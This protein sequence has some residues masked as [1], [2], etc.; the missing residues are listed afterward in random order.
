MYYNLGQPAHTPAPPRGISL[1]PPPPPVMPATNPLQLPASPLTRVPDSR[2]DPFSFIC[3]LVAKSHNKPGE[4][5]GTGIL[6]T[7]FH[8]LTCAHNIFPPQAPNT[9]EII[10]YPGQNGPDPRCHVRANAWA[11]HPSWRGTSCNT[12]GEDIGIIRLT[13]P[14]SP[15]FLPLKPFDVSALVGAS[16]S[17]AGYP[18]NREPKARH[19]Y[20]SRGAIT[21]GIRIDRCTGDAATGTA[22]GQRLPNITEATNLIAHNLETAASQSGSPM[23]IVQAG[24][25]VLVAVHTGRI[26]QNRQ[27]KA[28]LLNQAVRRRVADW[29]TALPPLQV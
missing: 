28:V 22:D 16:V 5:I 29:I 8:V 9:K 4:V 20:F 14:M 7:P 1:P 6:I 19:M 21:G 25:R 3:R 17:L 18:F 10:V 11:I 26:D 24:G 27:G 15:G 2:V 12:A 23:W 13:C